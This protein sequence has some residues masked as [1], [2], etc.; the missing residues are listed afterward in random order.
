MT[1]NSLNR[2]QLA[3]IGGI[4]AILTVVSYTL[5]YQ[6]SPFTDS[7]NRALTNVLTIFSALTC[8]LIL[9]LI[10]KFYQPGEPPKR[11]WFYF[12][13]SLWM[14][15]LGEIIWGVYNMTVGEVPDFTLAD[16]LWALSYLSFSAAIVSQ[17]RLVFFDT[18]RR[19]IWMAAATWVIV[20][21]LTSLTLVLAK[22]ESFFGEFLVYFYPFADFALALASLILILTFRQGSLARPWLSLFAFAVSDGFY[23]WA[24]STGLYDWS[25]SS[26]SVITF[27]AD[28][29]YVIAYLIMGWGVFQQYLTLRFGAATRRNTTP[30]PRPRI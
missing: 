17:Y 1:L 22:S 16:I 2:A 9:T 29:T 28:I 27:I 10:L 5:I 7:I 6:F 15:T 25:A 8:A 26:G 30:A 19:L 21:A 20:L 11:I 18:S 3:R 23:I 13:I 24:T 12:A 14:W 4:Y